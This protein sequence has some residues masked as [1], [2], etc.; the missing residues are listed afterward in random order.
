[1][2]RLILIKMNLNPPVYGQFP[3]TRLRRLRQAPWIR[4]LVAENS[5]TVQDFVWPIFIRN[6]DSP[7]EIP[8]MPGVFRLTCAELIPAVQQAADLGITA[9]ALFPYTPIEKRT[10]DGAEALNPQNLVCQ[11]IRLIKKHVPAMGVITDVALDPYTDHGHDGLLQNGQIVND[12]SVAVLCQQALNQAEAGADVLAPSDMMDGRVAAIRQALDE[13]G[14][15]DR[16]ILSYAVKYASAFYGPFRDA[17]GVQKLIGVTDKKSYQLNPANAQEALREVALDLQEGADAIMVKPGLPYL[18]M[19]KSIAQMCSAPIF[20]YQ[21][22]GEY[23]MIKAAAEKGWI[24]GDLA[25]MESLTAF[26][27]A[28]ACGIFTYA[29]VDI[30]KKL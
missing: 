16:M 14:F 29:A 21:V 5:L 27:R 30:A 24:D 18:D 19:I 13:H 20:A 7:S 10:P 26:K 28:G 22:S 2:K 6:T 15:Q 17:V 1:M 3:Q 9:V 23:A 8:A 12:P 11:A 25:M 4:N